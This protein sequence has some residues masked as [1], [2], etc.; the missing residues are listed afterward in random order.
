MKTSSKLLSI[1]VPSLVVGGLLLQSSFGR[2]DDRIPAPP[3][4]PVAK[5]PKPPKAPHMAPGLGGFDAQM[6]RAMVRSK[7]QEARKSVSSAAMPPAMR[8]KV[9]AR[10][11]RVAAIVDR[12]LATVDFSK[13]DE[14]GEQLEGMGEELE[15]A[16]EGLDQEL[17]I[18]LKHAF[19]LKDLQKLQSLGNLHLSFDDD[20]ADDADDTDA[21]D[22]STPVAPVPPVAPVAPVAPVPPPPPM[23]NG[24]PSFDLPDDDDMDAEE[25]QLRGDQVARL[26]AVRTATDAKVR[27]SKEQLDKLSAELESLLRDPAA[28]AGQV[29]SMIDRISAL[30]ATIRKARINAWMQSRALLDARQRQKLGQP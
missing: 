9:L 13:L 1:A 2:A 22:F 4:P 15:Q 29:N 14:L 5:A 27:A 24:V 16:M 30:E 28:S 7:L 20:D 25:L 6:V 8:D 23:V 19:N 10:L 12:R 3:P 26:R 21:W 11:D 17:E 18:V